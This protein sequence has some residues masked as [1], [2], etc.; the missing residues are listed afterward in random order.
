MNISEKRNGFEIPMLPSRTKWTNQGREGDLQQDT[1]L[2][3][4]I[5]A[6]RTSCTVKYY[7]IYLERFLIPPNT[8]SPP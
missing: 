7:L 2:L 6:C 5:N 4:Q 3:R 1:V 8:T